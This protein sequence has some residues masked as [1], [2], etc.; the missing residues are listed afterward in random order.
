VVCG[1]GT[2]HHPSFEIVGSFGEVGLGV[3]GGWMFAVGGAG[4]GGEV[5]VVGVGVLTGIFVCELC[6]GFVA[7]QFV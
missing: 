5:A 6:S 3:V 4:R 2:D 1:G 7:W